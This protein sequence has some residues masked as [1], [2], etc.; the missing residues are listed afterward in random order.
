ME[1]AHLFCIYIHEENGEEKTAEF[2][3][4][5]PNQNLT[6]PHAITRVLKSEIEKELGHNVIDF[7]TFGKAPVGEKNWKVIEQE[8]I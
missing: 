5:K 4:I 7:F 1:V 3:T 2:E 8:R 6:D